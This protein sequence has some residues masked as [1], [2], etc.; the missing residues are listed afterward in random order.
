MS[1]LLIIAFVKERKG[2]FAVY[3][4]AD[5]NIKNVSTKN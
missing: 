2:N 5:G 4:D 1:S 3:A